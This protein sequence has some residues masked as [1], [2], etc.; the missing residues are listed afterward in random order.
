LILKQS[1]LLCFCAANQELTIEFNRGRSNKR[2]KVK[3]F[4]KYKQQ[5]FLDL[6]SSSMRNSYSNYSPNQWIKINSQ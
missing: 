5:S 2:F 4:Y 1:D 6:F 3:V